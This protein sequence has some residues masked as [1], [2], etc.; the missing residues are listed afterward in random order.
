MNTKELTRKICYRSAAF[1]KKNAA[2]VLTVIG[3]VGVI[4]T[5]VSA[6][7]ATPKAIT[8]IKN[9]EEE[10]KRKLSKTEIL[11]VTGKEYIP[12]VICG[13]LTISCIFGANVLNKK[14]QAALTSAYA[15]LDNSYREYRSKTKEL[16]GEEADLEIRKKM[17]GDK[18]EVCETNKNKA[19][20]CRNEEVM[21]Y[22]ELS[23]RYFYSTIEAVQ[24]A[25]YHLNRNFTLRG[26][27]ELNELY[28][29]LGLYPTEY[30]TTVGWSL[31]AGAEFYGYSWIDFEHTLVD[32]DDPDTPPYYLIHCT[33]PPTADF[34]D[35]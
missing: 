4:G 13:T 17:S 28:D 6:V 25:E 27:S 10:K 15:F 12:A 31:E 23:N 11:A 29:F 7:S 24:A 19:L 20:P 26:Y 2:T 21:F 30:G 8:L 1:L 22:D 35:F 9:A 33:F 32:S 5:A 3:S 34:L 16:Y 18:H 14:Q